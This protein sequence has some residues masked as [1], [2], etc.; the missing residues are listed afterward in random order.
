M[1]ALAQGEPSCFGW[2]CVK[3]LFWDMAMI[4]LDDLVTGTNN[5]LVQGPSCKITVLSLEL[6]P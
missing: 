6:A 5:G 4:F 1:V 2:Y 3:N